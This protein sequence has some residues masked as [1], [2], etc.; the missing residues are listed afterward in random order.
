MHDSVRGRSRARRRGGAN[1]TDS[2]DTEVEEGHDG[3]MDNF[4]DLQLGSMTP[5]VRRKENSPSSSLI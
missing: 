5:V 4:Q 1:I 3:E 2:E